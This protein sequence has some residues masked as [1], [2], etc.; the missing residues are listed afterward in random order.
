MSLNPTHDPA[1]RS[2]LESA[3]AETTDF[4][5]Q[6]LPF[7]V[8][9]T[10]PTAPPRIG[11]AIGSSILDLTAAAR[12]GLV[13]VV[14]ATVETDGLIGACRQSSLNALMTLGPAHWSVLRARLSELLGADTCPAGP[15]RAAV[16][17]CLVPQAAAEML[18]PAAI[19][20]YTDFYASIFHATNVGAMFRPDQPLLPN[21]PWVPIGYHGRSSSIMVSGSPVRRPQGQTRAAGETAPVFGPTGQLDYE[22]ELGAFVGPGNVLGSPVPVA[23]APGHLFGFALLNDWSARDIQSWE[24][25]PLGPFLAKNF[26]TTVSPWIV[27]AEALAPFRTAAFARGAGDP[28]PLPYLSDPRDQAAGGIDVTLEVWLLTAGMR[29][30]GQAPHRLTAGNFKDMYWTVAQLLAHH[31]SN[32][33]NLRPGDLIG[34]GTVSGPTKDSRGCLL[35]LTQRGAEPV[36]LPNG[37]A[38][39]F[40]ED[41]DEIILRGHASRP[42]A[43]RIGFGE[44]RGLV[45]PATV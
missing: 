40:L 19:G 4:P 22:L 27:T 12:T 15:G 43:R 32:G 34:S 37:E 45:L 39:A 33:C 5:L 21:Y 29:A 25:Q 31:T 6:N 24:Y 42:G 7:G 20:D 3:N 2:W 36:R 17:A 23:V 10:A 8:F 14:A 11:V 35:E 38:R 26:A 28:A 30:A 1:R 18:L 9:R 44:C 13:P 16:E 41:G